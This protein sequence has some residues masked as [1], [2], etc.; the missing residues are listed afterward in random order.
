MTWRGTGSHQP[1]AAN[2][3][4]TLFSF[5]KYRSPKQRLSALF[6]Q[7]GL[8]FFFL[9]ENQLSY[10]LHL[11]SFV[12]VLLSYSLKEIYLNIESKAVF[13]WLYFNNAKTVIYLVIR[14]GVV[15]HAKF[16]VTA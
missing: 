3:I 16:P 10:F 7:K 1:L 6:W 13:P 15:C 8:F 2:T 11:I 5:L 12:F 9:T 14:L 4:S